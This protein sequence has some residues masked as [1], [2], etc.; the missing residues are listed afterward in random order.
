MPKLASTED[1]RNLQEEARRTLRDR[2]KS[3]AR[4]II[5]MGTCGIAAG[6]RDTYQA[7]AAELQARGVDARLFGVG[8][9]GMCSREPLVDIDREGAG[10]ITYGPVP[11]DRVP[12]LV[13]EHLIGGRVVRE[14]AIGRLPAETSPPH[15]PPPDH[16]AVPL[17]AEL[18][19]YSKQQRI[20]L[21]S[22]QL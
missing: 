7:V 6:A 13:E 9:I 11:P 21:R 18:P 17:Y 2:T 20:A 19:F 5:G 8:C 15:P 12:R 1:F 16:A 22:L 14:W 4:I 10:R 3:G